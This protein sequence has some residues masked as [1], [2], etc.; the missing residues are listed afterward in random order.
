[1]NT[2]EAVSPLRYPGGKQKLFPLVKLIISKAEI[3]GCTYVEPF[4]GGAGVALSLLF[5]EAVQ[6]IVINDYD[7][8]IASFWKA[9]LSEPD[10]FIDRIQTIPLSIKE[11]KRQKEIYFSSARYSFDFGFAAFYLNRTNHSGILKGGPIGGFSQNNDKYNIST[12]F[13]RESLSAKI[14]A[15][16][17]K[18]DSIKCYNQDALL[19]I[20]KQLPKIGKNAFIYFDPPYYNNGRRLYKDFYEGKDHRALANEIIAFNNAPWI[21]SYDNVPEIREMYNSL[22]SRTFSLSYS[23]ANNGRGEEIVFFKT[24]R[25]CPTNKEIAKLNIN[26]FNWR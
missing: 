2:K 12:R 21:V 13:N 11:W 3:D 6:K 25:L 7:R 23:L 15:I 18:R 14:L 10:Q 1:M 19:F 4:A 16:K 20:K 26:L 8:A 9:V 5:E 17:E 24:P 22:I